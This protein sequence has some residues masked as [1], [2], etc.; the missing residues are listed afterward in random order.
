[1]QFPYISN[2]VAEYTS[3]RIV[4]ASESDLTVPWQR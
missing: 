1:M 4:G 3:V 2:E